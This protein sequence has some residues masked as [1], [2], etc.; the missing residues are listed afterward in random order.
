MRNVENRIR[1]FLSDWFEE[2]GQRTD[3]I[4]MEIFWNKTSWKVLGL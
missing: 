4:R 2:R 3:S 1:Q